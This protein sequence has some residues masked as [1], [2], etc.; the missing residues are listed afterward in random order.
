MHVTCHVHAFYYHMHACH[1]LTVN[2]MHVTVLRSHAR[3]HDTVSPG[4]TRVGTPKDTALFVEVVE[5][6]NALV[7]VFGWSDPEHAYTNI[8]SHA[9]TADIAGNVMF[10]YHSFGYYSGLFYTNTSG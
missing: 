2:S 8:T 6:S 4:S 7:S 9:G 3:M 10:G 5:H 1:W